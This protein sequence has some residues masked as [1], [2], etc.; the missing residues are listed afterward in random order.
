MAALVFQELLKLEQETGSQWKALGEART[1]AGQVCQLIEQA[2]AEPV[3]QMSS[4]GSLVV[5]GSLA[6]GEWTVGSDVD[7]ALLIDGLAAPEHYECSL[8][9]ERALSELTFQDQPL[10]PPGSTG[11]FGQLVFSHDLVHALGGEPDTNVNTTRRLLLLLE[12]TAIGD[13]SAHSRT[14]RSVLRRYLLDDLRT[15]PEEGSRVPRFLV[16][17]IVRFWRTMCV[18]F[19]A[20]HWQQSGKKWGIRNIKLRMSRKLL[21]VSG[22]LMALGCDKVGSRHAQ[23]EDE[24][25]ERLIHSAELPPLE[26]VVSEL[27]TWGLN[28]KASELVS[29][30]DE[31]LLSMNHP[32]K[33]AALNEVKPQDAADHQV[34][35]EFR[36][37]SQRFQKLLTAMFFEAETRLS[38]LVREYGVF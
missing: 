18:D 37:I 22:L 31:F 33:R 20:K 25:L 16:N 4:D 17:D 30:Y 21:F 15:K 32:A 28:Q 12:S 26:V 38:E 19:G 3:Q 6:R 23:T 35:L 24:V 9:I 14:I 8:E 11:T 2:A 10:I 1:S 13:A 34:F 29:V 27:A 7:W 36:E 5:F